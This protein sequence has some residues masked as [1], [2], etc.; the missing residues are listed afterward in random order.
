MHTHPHRPERKR[1]LVVLDFDGFLVNSYAL[2]RETFA[3]FGLDVG[4]EERFRNRR[5]FLKYLGGG[6]E[7]LTNLV[8]FALPKERRI[9]EVLTE[10]YRTEGLVYPEFR[11]VVNRLIAS[12]RVHCG[13]VSRNFTLA[14]GPTMRCVLKR[15]GIAEAELDFVIPIPA[16]T[17]K[18][19]TLAAM[20]SS[21]Y[22]ECLLGAD[23]ISDYRAAT[24]A[25]YEVLMAS[26]GFDHRNRLIDRG[27]VPGALIYDDP[28]TL[29]TEL[30]DHV[31][32]YVDPPRRRA[33][34]LPPPGADFGV[35]AVTAAAAHEL[36]AFRRHS[37]SPA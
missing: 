17:P 30:A 10:V 29:A 34:S 24:A 21:R 15:S 18:D 6:K 20:R 27:D 36:T 19:E 12:P 11:D 33:L 35:N 28:A 26:Y 14:P 5:K 22:H 37:D 9:R 8:R 16:G 3:A 2:I 25:G 1:L 23:E 4:D 7:F 31:A 32:P 13:V